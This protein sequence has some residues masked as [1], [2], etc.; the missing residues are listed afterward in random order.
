[1]DWILAVR[2]HITVEYKNML[3]VLIVF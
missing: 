2:L 3:P 1:M